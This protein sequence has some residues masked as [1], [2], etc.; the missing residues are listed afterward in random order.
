ML[1]CKRCE[2]KHY[3]S[4]CFTIISVSCQC[5]CHINRSTSTTDIAV[6]IPYTGNELSDIEGNDET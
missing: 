2:E 4:H 3:V 6:S 5:E 1:H